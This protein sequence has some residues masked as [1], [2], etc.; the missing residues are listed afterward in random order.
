MNYFKLERKCKKSE[1]KIEWSS[2]NSTTLSFKMD[3]MTRLILW[4]LGLSTVLGIIKYMVIP[5]LM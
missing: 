2:N 1:I 3:F 4:T 5:M